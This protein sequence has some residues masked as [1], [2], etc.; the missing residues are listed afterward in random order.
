MFPELTFIMICGLHVLLG[1][2]KAGVVL[3]FVIYQ[4][5]TVAMDGSDNDL[6]S[7]N[8]NNNR[9]SSVSRVSE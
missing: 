9:A 1:F 7:V 8:D 4:V 6:G 2:V 5:P 3:Y